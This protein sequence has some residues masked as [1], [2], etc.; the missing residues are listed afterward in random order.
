MLKHVPITL[1]ALLAPLFSSCMIVLVVV[2]F[3][4][5]YKAAERKAHDASTAL[6]LNEDVRELSAQIETTQAL[7][8]RFSSW[9]QTGTEIDESLGGVTG[10]VSNVERINQM[11]SAFESEFQ[12]QEDIAALLG[13]IRKTFD[14]YNKVFLR[15]ADVIDSNPYI[16]T[17]V[18]ID[19]YPAFD[20]LLQSSVELEHFFTDYLYTLEE[21]AFAAKHEALIIVFT[22]S[23]FAFLASLLAGLL[24]GRAIAIPVKRLSHV[25]GCL[26]GV[27]YDV[28]VTGTENRDE[29]GVMAMAVERLKEQLQEKKRLED[30]SQDAVN[31]GRIRHALG[32]A[33]TNMIVTDEVGNAIFINHSMKS[34]LEDVAEHLP[35]L[36][37]SK[38]SLD[39][40]HLNLAMLL[41]NLATSDLLSLSGI[42]TSEQQLGAFYLQQIISPVFDDKD[43][44]IG[45]VFEW[46][47]MT[48]QKAKEAQ[49][50]E[51]N[52]RELVQAEKL[53]T[54]ADDLLQVVGAALEGDLTRRITVEG[55]DAIG[56]IGSALGRFFASLGGDIREISVNADDLNEFS[57]E[58]EALNKEMHGL[59]Q[60][61]SQ[62][63]DQVSSASDEISNN[64]SSVSVAV[65]QMDSSIREIARNSEQASV[66]A[67]N[68][69][70]IAQSADKL[71]RQL[72]ESSVSIGAMIKV[73]TSIAEQTNL[74]ALNAT[75]EAARA[76]DAG[77]G[78]AV[79]ANE[80]KDLAK[81]TANATDEIR[82]R[83]NAIQQDSDGAVT[84]ISEISDIIVSISSLQGQ[85]ATGIQE[86]KL[87][88]QGISQSASETDARTTGIIQNIAK[89]SASS[90]H[91][92][93]G[94]VR[95]QESASKLK[96]MA[97]SMHALVAQF[98]I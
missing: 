57:L 20:A 94:A 84:A 98:T 81:E 89:V 10:L 54:G 23:G 7:L 11:L 4:S 69:V 95:A 75:I 12:V 55:S 82:R 88:T 49:I 6:A 32:S 29:I 36:A 42:S 70:R 85:I 48:Q 71:M 3:Y 53:R 93:A 28:P 63:I 67:G 5:S 92:L 9:M 21:A 14:E 45:L 62:Q 47:D 64:A 27:K 61:A 83:I 79:V 37:H 52:A 96:N 43:Q 56:Q 50:Q 39:L 80:V 58:F 17:N 74:L 40:E 1:K 44:Q 26:A 90:E 76:G 25:I 97:G 13:A 59:A 68:A 18:L 33:N 16:S 73:I 86:Q 87:A 8:S 78:F 66:V 72:S 19:S 91:T 22:V 38:G 41:N 60:E 2:V 51:A 30:E 65:K 34:L 15:T 35:K 46:I 77:K 31:N 24:L